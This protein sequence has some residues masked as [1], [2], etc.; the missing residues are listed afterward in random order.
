MRFFS[1]AFLL[2]LL[3]VVFFLQGCA[4]T[5]YSMHGMP[6]KPAVETE[7]QNQ[8]DV[9]HYMPQQGLMSVYTNQTG[10]NDLIIG[11][12]NMAT[13]SKTGDKKLVTLETSLGK[14]V[15]ELYPDKAPATV[16]NFLSYV[17]SGF[18]DGL[19]FHR[20]IDGFMIQGGGFTSDGNQKPTGSPIKL[21]SDNGLKNVRGSVAMARTN[22]P[23]SATSQFFINVVDNQPLDYAPGNLGYAVFGKVVSGMEVVDKIKSVK[24]T[25][26]HGF[27][28]NWPVEEIVITKASVGQ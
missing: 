8:V 23:D 16:A 26:K 22:E 5:D 27:Y 2:S 10:T 12:T 1:I 9:S 13:D 17:E 14:I 19:V 11:D 15:L 20:V 3:I 6:K 24:T 25:T 7:A 28:E 18:Y 21:E 4:K